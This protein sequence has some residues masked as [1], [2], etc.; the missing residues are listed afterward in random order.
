MSGQSRGSE[1]SQR[2]LIEKVKGGLGGLSGGMTAVEQSLRKFTSPGTQNVSQDDLI[3]GL[4]RV[5]AKLTL[6]EIKEFFA[7]CRNGEKARA[8]NESGAGADLYGTTP[9]ETVQVAEIMQ[10]LN[11]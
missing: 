4:S 3:I 7:L 2:N 1:K 9:S 11:I 6:D 10:L 5:G 8:S